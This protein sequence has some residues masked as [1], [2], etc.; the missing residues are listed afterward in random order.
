MTAF[1]SR[2]AWCGPDS[3]VTCSECGH[4]ADRADTECPNCHAAF[5]GKFTDGICPTCRK[6]N[7]PMN[8]EITTT[9]GAA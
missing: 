9:D 2:C 6:V 3:P 5:S 8:H 7:F 4:P 1:F